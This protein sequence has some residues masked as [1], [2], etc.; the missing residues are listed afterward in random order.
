MIAIG[1]LTAELHSRRSDGNGVLALEQLNRSND[2]N[3]Y[4]NMF[5]FKKQQQIDTQ[6]DTQIH[7]LP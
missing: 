7:K 1:S 2:F 3:S 6:I 5:H 4:F